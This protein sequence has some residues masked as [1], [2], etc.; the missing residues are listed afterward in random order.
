M[1]F[2][3]TLVVQEFCVVSDAVC[4]EP[5][6]K[7]ARHCGFRGCDAFIA[8]LSIVDPKLLSWESHRETSM[9]TRVAGSV[10]HF[11]KGCLACCPRWSLLDCGYRLPAKQRRPP[12]VPL[13]RPERTWTIVPVRWNSISS[14]FLVERGVFSATRFSH[15]LQD[16]SGGRSFTNASN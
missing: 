14:G 13:G 15:G 9:R 2:V 8:E 4:Q 12:P 3:C 6:L 16:R 5:R 1:V 11:P 10:S 7:Y